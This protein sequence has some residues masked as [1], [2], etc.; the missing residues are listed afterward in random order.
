MMNV[1]HILQVLY[2]HQV[3]YLLIGGMNFLLNHKPELTFDLDIWVEDKPENL[4]TLNLALRDLEAAWGKTEEA[5]KPV[6]EDPS[7]LQAQTLFCLTSR[8]GA[9][10]IFRKVL[11]LDNPFRESKA[12]ATLQKTSAG[13]LYWSLS[14]ADM[15][16]CQ[17]ALPLAE[18]K[19]LRIQTLQAALL[20]KD[21]GS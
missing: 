15:L 7:W 6:S 17:L 4:S 8:H 21:Y 10:D 12:R 2:D 3:D 11:G 13:T 20:K 14:D 19:P 5:W 16:R 1:D 9:L 18:Q